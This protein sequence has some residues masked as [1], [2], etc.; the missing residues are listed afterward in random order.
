M[1]VTICLPQFE[2]STNCC[3]FLLSLFVSICLFQGTSAQEKKLHRWRATWQVLA[4]CRMN[5]RINDTFKPIIVPFILFQIGFSDS[6]VV[7]AFLC[8]DRCIYSFLLR[9]KNHYSFNEIEYTKQHKYHNVEWA[10]YNIVIFL[11]CI[12]EDDYKLNESIFNIKR[13]NFVSFSLYLHA[14]WVI[15]L[16]RSVVYLAHLVQPI[17]HINFFYRIYKRNVYF[18]HT[19]LA[20]SFTRI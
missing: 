20:H 13:Y 19:V 18:F 4:I 9:D 3:F 11:N 5:R 6:V 7:V 14:Y 1:F 15:Y 17:F 10:I 16:S 8:S 2:F 12:D